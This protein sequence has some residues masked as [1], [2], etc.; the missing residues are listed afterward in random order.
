M[1]ME[2]PVNSEGSRGEQPKEKLV[3]VEKALDRYFDFVYGA[4]ERSERREIKT[5]LLGAIKEDFSNLIEKNKNLQEAIENG[6]IDKQ[7]AEKAIIAEVTDQ[8]TI[9]KEEAHSFYRLLRELLPEEE[10]DNS[11]VTYP[12]EYG[13]SGEY[14]RSYTPTESSSLFPR[15][16]LLRYQRFDLRPPY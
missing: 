4:S 2:M 13:G 6:E 9:S 11:M 10:R 5:G 16:S 1:N 7:T 12:D 3:G 14:Q 15:S 8:S